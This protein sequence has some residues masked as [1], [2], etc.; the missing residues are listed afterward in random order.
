[1]V[2]ARNISLKK[3]VNEDIQSTSTSCCSKKFVKSCRFIS[4]CHAENFI[5]SS[6]SVSYRQNIAI[7]SFRFDISIVM[8]VQEC[9]IEIESLR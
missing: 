2:E 7:C 1:M 4:K 8:K 6:L 5:C 9:N 3:D